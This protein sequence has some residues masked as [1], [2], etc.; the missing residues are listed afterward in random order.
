[1]SVLHKATPLVM[2]SMQECEQKEIVIKCFE[3]VEWKYVKILVCCC[4]P[5]SARKVRSSTGHGIAVNSHCTETM[6]TREDI[7]IVPIASER[8]LK[9]T[10][11]VK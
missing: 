4:C 11:T 9:N 8:S 5:I 3:A 6:V 2:R 1:M 7:I 10:T